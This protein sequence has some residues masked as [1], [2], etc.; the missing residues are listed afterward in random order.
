MKNGQS[1]MSQNILSNYRMNSPIN[2]TLH[3]SFLN[4]SSTSNK[5]FALN[6]T[7]PNLA[8]S[9]MDSIWNKTITVNKE[10][11]KNKKENTLN[12]S[13]S[14]NKSSKLYQTITYKTI[15]NHPLKS[16]IESKNKIKSK[17]GLK[18]SKSN[19]EIKENIVGV[20]SKFYSSLQEEYENLKNKL[21]NT[22]KEKDDCII[23]LNKKLKDLEEEVERLK[24]LKLQ[25]MEEKLKK[26]SEMN[27]IES[28]EQWD[29]TKEEPLLPP[30]PII[31]KNAEDKKDPLEKVEINL[32]S[33]NN[34]QNDEVIDSNIKH[35][36]IPNN[37]YRNEEDKE[38][39][40]KISQLE[41]HINN[42][43][44]RNNNLKKIDNDEYLSTDGVVIDS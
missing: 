34:N 16:Q 4:K 9:Y 20:S 35:N 22:K 27:E 28:N 14:N 15:N 30:E 26:I 6:K 32:T 12:K 33:S 3:K 42:D 37:N 13:M 17:G 21:K 5:S 41:E 38:N 36:I 7:E 23:D 19:K 8:Q 25:K 43:L 29:E 39:N 2:P 11:P 24:K 18:Q 44:L 10:F 40:L 1:S 31:Q